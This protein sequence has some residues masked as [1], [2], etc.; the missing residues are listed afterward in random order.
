MENFCH[1][2][3]DIKSKFYKYKGFKRYHIKLPTKEQK[4]IVTQSVINFKN[5][6]ARAKCMKTVMK[7]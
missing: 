2:V 3:V 7:S 5:A 4:K 1:K 6:S